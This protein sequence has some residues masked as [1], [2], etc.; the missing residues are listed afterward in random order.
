MLDDLGE[1]SMIFLDGKAKELKLEV[2][3]E[4]MELVM[5]NS[6]NWMEIL[7]IKLPN[8]LPSTIFTSKLRIKK[9]TMIREP[10]LNTILSLT[11]QLEN[12]I[13][14]LIHL[15]LMFSGMM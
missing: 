3:K 14:I 12:R 5:S 11:G 8:S 10:L 9:R 15:R 7:I 13:L 2:D 6:V 1:F 4:L